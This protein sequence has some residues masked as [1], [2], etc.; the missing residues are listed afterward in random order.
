MCGIRG[1]GSRVQ[2]GRGAPRVQHVPKSLVIVHAYELWEAF[3]RSR[4]YHEKQGGRD[5]VEAKA[6]VARG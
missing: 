6:P 3:T 5:W 2:I 4:D 1:R